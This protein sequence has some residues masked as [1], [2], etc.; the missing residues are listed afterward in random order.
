MFKYKSIHYKFEQVNTK[1]IQSNA[2]TAERERES[3]TSGRQKEKR[4][5]ETPS[6]GQGLVVDTGHWFE[7]CNRLAQFRIELDFDGAELLLL[8]FSIQLNFR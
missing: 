1:S 7:P 3:R 2:K 5:E 8:F 4:K 6:T